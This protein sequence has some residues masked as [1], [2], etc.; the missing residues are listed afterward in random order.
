MTIAKDN[1]IYQAWMCQDSQ[2]HEGKAI[3]PGQF[4]VDGVGPAAG[5]YEAEQFWKKFHGC[6]QPG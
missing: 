2:E 1:Q 3:K 5:V 6:V 4:V